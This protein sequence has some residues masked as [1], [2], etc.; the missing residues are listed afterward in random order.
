MLPFPVPRYNIGS[1][2]IFT[3]PVD[4]VR[5]CRVLK[6]SSVVLDPEAAFLCL[7]P[8]ALG[9]RPASNCDLDICHGGLFLVLRSAV[10][11]RI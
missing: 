10:A 4:F 9:H 3:S 6:T 11:G 7:C 5:V 2:T 1:T 8:L